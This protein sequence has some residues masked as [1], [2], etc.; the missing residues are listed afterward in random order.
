[1][2]LKMQKLVRIKK[3]TNKC[4]HIIF[5]KKNIIDK[6][7]HKCLKIATGIMTPEWPKHK[8]IV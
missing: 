5:S 2:I 6:Y 4:V 1:M 7:A 8:K 3:M